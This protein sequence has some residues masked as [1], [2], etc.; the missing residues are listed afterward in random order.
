MIIA[1]VHAEYHAS[2][3]VDHHDGVVD[4]HI[5]HMDTRLSVILEIRGDVR[6][7][8]AQSVH[9]SELGVDEQSR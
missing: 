8:C 6:C 1:K 7:N 5:G 4:R 9:C 2:S 3:E